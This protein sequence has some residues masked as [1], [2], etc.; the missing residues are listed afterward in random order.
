MARRHLGYSKRLH[1]NAA[2]SDMQTA[3]A[4]INKAVA[5]LRRGSC[6]GAFS[7]I[8]AAYEAMGAAHAHGRAAGQ[9]AWLPQRAV[10][11]VMGKYNDVCMIAE[12][13]DVG[14][15]WSPALAGRRHKRRR[16]R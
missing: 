10:M 16:R 3:R 15:H 13:V 12:K 6:H 4:E 14:A 2:E 11:D 7:A 9:T 1:S 5:A 8:T